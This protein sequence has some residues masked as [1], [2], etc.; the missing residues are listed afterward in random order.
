MAN[1]TEAIDKC[2]LLLIFSS[3]CAINKDRKSVQLLADFYHIMF[4]N[5]FPFL[6]FIEM[7]FI[8]IIV[9]IHG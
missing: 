4:Q 2:L 6:K 7:N 5:W 1:H 9:M 8:M 3:L